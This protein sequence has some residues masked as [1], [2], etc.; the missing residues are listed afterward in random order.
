MKAPN[1]IAHI[2]IA[3]KSLDHVLPFYTEQLGLKLLGKEEVASEQV[4]VAFLEI[5]ESRIELLEPLSEESPI[6][7]F[8]EKRGEGIHHIALDVDDVEMRLVTLKENGVP[9][10]HEKPKEG[11][12]QAQIGFLHPKAAQGVLYEL[13]QYP[14]DAAH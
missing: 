6:A 12:H 10:I 9:L 8:I 3:V 7:K 11:A 5:G 4:R 14:K 13:C 2:G 1:K